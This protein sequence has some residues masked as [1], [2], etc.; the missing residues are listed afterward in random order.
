MDRPVSLDPEM[1]RIIYERVDAKRSIGI[2]VGVNVPG[3]SDSYNAPMM[4]RARGSGGIPAC[5]WL[6]V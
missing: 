4:R 5:I 6:M 3:H 1:V 2:V